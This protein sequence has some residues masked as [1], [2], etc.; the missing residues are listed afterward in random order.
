[1]SERDFALYIHIPFCISKCSYCD[2]FSITDCGEEKLDNYI[3]SLCKEIECRLNRFD[4]VDTGVNG[5][6]DVCDVRDGVIKSIYIGGGTPSLL[7]EKHFEKIFDAVKTC[8]PALFLAVDCEITIE[9]NP[10]DV[11]VEL[12][13]ALWKNGVNR[14]SV[15]IQSMNDEVLKNVRRRAGRKENLE[16]LKIIS[17]EWKGIF[18]VDLISALPLES[19][20]SFE[21]GLEEVIKYNPHHISLYSLTIEEETPLG[22]QVADGL[23]DYDFD[24]ADKMW[25]LGRKFLEENGYAQY[26]VSNFA[27]A[28]YECKHNLFYWNHKPYFGCGSGAT[29]SLYKSDGRGFRWTNAEDV[30]RYIQ[31]WG[32]KGTEL[33]G[34]SLNLSGELPLNLPQ[35]EEIVCLNDSKFEFFMMGLRK[36]CGITDLEYR[37][38]FGEELPEK[39]VKLAKEWR[40]KGL[41]EIVDERLDGRL[42]DERPLD[43][44][45]GVRYK[46]SGEGILFLNRF[47][48]LLEL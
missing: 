4:F 33:G 31:F 24:F 17:G 18:S 13:R 42:L 44:S 41:F 2:F 23:L 39:F 21:K 27:R 9:L 3:D 34:K 5:V 8:S 30:E 10:D 19:M 25:L 22:K 35:N 45:M 40:E 48:S 1:M 43:G 36:M 38:I 12:L 15:G 47:L 32:E 37:Q 26:E 46:M 14:I 29:G 6:R 20:E 16:A 11:S 7:K 28:G